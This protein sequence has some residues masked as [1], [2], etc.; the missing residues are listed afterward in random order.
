MIESTTRTLRFEGAHIPIYIARPEASPA[1][2]VLMFGAIWSVTPHIQDLCNRLAGAGFGAIA[3]CLFRNTG[4]PARAAPP[5]VLA[6][7]FADFDDSRCI[8]DLRATLHAARSGLFDFAP[9]RVV[10]LGFCLGGRF[11]HYIAAFDRKCA[12]IVNFYGRLR[13]ERSALKPFL[14]AEVTGLIEMPYLG[15]FAEFDPLIAHADVDEL[16]TALAARNVP[17]RIEVYAG[18]R[19]GFVDPERPAEHDPAAAE[20]AWATTLEFL[21][22]L[23]TGKPPFA[24]MAPSASAY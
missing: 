23:A 7:T 14:P 13:F 1:L 8:R 20:R 11:A 4:I 15:H 19:H 24:R 6:Q 16:R 3:P 12:G 9:G 17:Q 5:E 18:T 2:T 10:P 22:A 21:H